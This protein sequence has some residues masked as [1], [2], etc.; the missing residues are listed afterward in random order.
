MKKKTPKSK[1]QN[2][3]FESTKSTHSI[4][5]KNVRYTP[6]NISVLSGQEYEEMD[7]T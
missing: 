7:T 6:S 2:Q 1:N 4:K 5:K 3:D